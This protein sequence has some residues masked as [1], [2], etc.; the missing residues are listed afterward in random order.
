MVMSFLD[1]RLI[2]LISNVEGMEDDESEA[3]D[4]ELLE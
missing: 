2:S 3:E 1:K 4:F